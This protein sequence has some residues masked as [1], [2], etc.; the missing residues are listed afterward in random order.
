MRLIKLIRRISDILGQIDY[1]RVAAI[2][3]KIVT[4][5]EAIFGDSSSTKADAMTAA[6]ESNKA[7]AVT[8]ALGVLSRADE[9]ELKAAGFNFGLLVEF[10][11][12]IISLIKSL[13]PKS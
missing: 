8:Q 10:I 5:L 3:E 1:E 12:L 4:Q 7:E 6:L 2:I 9:E 11:N 13:K